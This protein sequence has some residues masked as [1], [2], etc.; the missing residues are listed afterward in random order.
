MPGAVLTP[1]MMPTKYLREVRSLI[2]Y[3]HQWVR[4]RTCVQNTSAWPIS[5]IEPTKALV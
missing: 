1:S 4:N 2:L 3:R 5:R